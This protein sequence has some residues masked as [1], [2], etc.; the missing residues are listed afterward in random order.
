MHQPRGYKEEHQPQL[1]ISSCETCRQLQ[2]VSLQLPMTFLALQCGTPLHAGMTELDRT[3][4]LSQ[5]Y[6][7]VI[8]QN[9][10]Q[11]QHLIIKALN[12]ANHLIHRN[13][14]RSG[15]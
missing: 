11:F 10:L 9:N 13:M 7:C 1:I 14:Q 15:S 2:L 3:Y 12:S 5:T 4:D 6:L 8:Y